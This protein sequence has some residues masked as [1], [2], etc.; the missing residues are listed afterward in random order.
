MKRT[1]GA[2]GLVVGIVCAQTNVRAEPSVWAR[3]SDP[4]LQNLTDAEQAAEAALMRYR[5]A[6]RRPAIGDDLFGSGSLREQLF[7]R[8]AAASLEGADVARLGDASARLRLA[9]VLSEQ[10][11][12]EA[13]VPLLESLLREDAAAPIRLEAWKIAAVC[14][15]KLGR[16]G[17][18]IPAY[19]EA[20]KLEAY[21]SSRAVLLANQAEAFMVAGDLS[22]SV[23]GYRSALAL[24][25]TLTA[26]EIAAYAPT[27]YWGLAVALD[28]SS[29]RE[30]ALRAISLARAY[31][32]ED[33]RLSS[34]TWFFVP[35]YDE[36]WYRALGFWAH[37]R[38]LPSVDER[39]A[40]YVLSMQAWEDYLARADRADRWLSIA[41]AR[42]VQCDKE[43]RDL[44][45]RAKISH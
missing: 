38:T 36:A 28:R 24:L 34:D 45:R 20:L 27:T 1:A 3:A 12:C 13:A 2:L 33:R 14:Y 42:L 11:V 21:P 40:A 4:V 8:D 31:D 5:D 6:R 32:P 41:Q 22:R 39:S 25:G 7:L 37:A 10:D 19:E 9:E 18:E 26:V 29:D 43:R 35:S 16:H 44:L 17:Q 15:A 30:G 23:G